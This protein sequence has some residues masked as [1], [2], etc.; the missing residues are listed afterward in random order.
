[1]DTMLSTLYLR[2][3]EILDIQSGERF[4]CSV[5]DAERKLCQKYPTFRC[6]VAL[7]RDTELNELEEALGRIKRGTFGVCVRCGG[8]I[9]KSKLMEHPTAVLCAKCRR[10]ITAEA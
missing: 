10:E 5:C 8:G 7:K 1:M 4:E 3:D 6:A 9:P 2:P